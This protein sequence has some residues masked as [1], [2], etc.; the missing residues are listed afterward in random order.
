[1]SDP[2]RIHLRQTQT[3]RRLLQPCMAC[4]RSHGEPMCDLCSELEDAEEHPV[5]ARE[6]EPNYESLRLPGR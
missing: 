2:P 6:D 4:N 3:R 5:E 1:V